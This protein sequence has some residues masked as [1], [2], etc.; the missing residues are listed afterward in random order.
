MR[1]RNEA[2]FAQYL[3]STGVDWV[4]EPRAYGGTNGDYLPDFQLFERGHSLFVEL[5]RPMDPEDMASAVEL[6]RAMERM[7]II[8]QSEPDAALMLVTGDHAILGEAGHW[9]G[10]VDYPWM[11][12]VPR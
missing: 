1:S 11:R 5:K 2:R 7:E 6:E 3:D 10:T 8:W 12:H 4:Y 9:Q